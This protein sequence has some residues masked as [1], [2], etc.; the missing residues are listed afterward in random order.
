MRF[1]NLIRRA[2]PH[3][4]VMPS[5]KAPIELPKAPV[6]RIEETYT[7]FIK[8]LNKDEIKNVVLYAD[9]S[10]LI[11]NTIENKQEYVILPNNY[12]TLKLLMEKDIV[13]KI[14][15]KPN[16]NE[17][18][19]LIGES[20]F[21]IF[22]VIT[23][24]TLIRSST[25][26]I[27]MFGLFDKSEQKTPDTKFDDVGG[28]SEAKESLK[29]IVAFLEHPENY[30]AVGAKIPKG[31]LLYGPPGCSKTLL[32]RA[33]AGE[34]NVPFISCSG[35]DFIEMFVGIGASRIRDLFKKAQ[36]KA[37]CIIFIDEIDT[38]GKQ[39]GLIGTND[40]RDQT[41]NQLL[42]LMDGFETNTGVI[43]I[44]ATNRPDILDDALLRP[45][46]F[47]RMISV[48]L[49]DLASR[50]E[51]FAIHI[52]DKPIDKD[53]SIDSFARRTVGLSGADIMNIC[54]EAAIYA[55]RD[56]SKIIN[57]YHF[58]Q[59][60]EKS[61]LGEARKTLLITDEKKMI[62]AYHEAGHALTGLLL[63]D[64]DIVRKVSIIPRGET[65]GATYFEPTDDQIDLSLVT[66]E[67]LESQ[68]MVALG[69]RI[70]ESIVFGTMKITSGASGD[71]Q[72]VYSIA[73]DMIAQYG[74]NETLGPISWIDADAI[75]DDINKEIQF[76]VE[77]LYNKTYDML[78][79][80]ETLLH[81]IAKELIEKETL[82][83]DDLQKIIQEENM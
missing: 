23:G 21:I 4:Y 15:D 38:I 72:A 77:V 47:D 2:F 69:G 27:R 32:A 43:V 50:K 49:P 29:E 16:V 33:V 12:D 82:S 83:F 31:V 75:S 67:Y 61:M 13:V 36:S 3:E 42:T 26:N 64:Y 81:N 1:T 22:L 74:F 76:L 30:T 66:R 54:N 65:G 8:Q 5:F 17:S 46:R 62:L 11:A 58:E 52:R 34:A 51:I 25:T 73:Y 55:A 6:V 78:S 7:D 79:N 18:I 56:N 39:R 45:G 60:L 9:Q 68:I 41:I 44:A 35:S 19:V 80:N 24:I 28:S 10:Q 57:N 40:E 48:N 53:V 37:P 20:F 71:L 59:S 14:Q 63:K 70:S